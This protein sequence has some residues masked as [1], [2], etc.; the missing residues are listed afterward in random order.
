MSEVVLFD[1]SCPICQREIDFYTKIDKTCS[2]E[3]VDINGEDDRLTELGISYQAAMAVFHVRDQQG[4]WH[5]GA[6]AFVVLWYA[7]PYFRHLA[8]II[9]KLRLTGL[10]DR[11]YRV[12]ARNRRTGSRCDDSCRTNQTPAKEIAK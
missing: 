3:W 12:F 7:L 8:W 1:G 11:A 4:V 2:I 10:M 9:D 5:Q 6:H